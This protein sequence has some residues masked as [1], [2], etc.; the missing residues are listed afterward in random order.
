MRSATSQVSKPVAMK[1]TICWWTLEKNWQL[2]TKLG[3]IPR[4]SA[5]IHQSTLLMANKLENDLY[6]HSLFQTPPL[7]PSK[8]TTAIGT[9]AARMPCCSAWQTPTRRPPPSPG[10][11]KNHTQSICAAH[12]SPSSFGES[13]SII[14]TKVCPKIIFFSPGLRIIF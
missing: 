4:M 8:A 14:T 5:S 1:L 3:K 2:E 7:C 6:L 10:L 11:R 13:F 12:P 9:S